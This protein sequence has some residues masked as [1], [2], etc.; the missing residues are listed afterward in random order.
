MTAPA[1]QLLALSGPAAVFDLEWTAWEG[2]QAR[3][4]SGPGELQEIVEIGAVLLDAGDGLRETGAFSMLV[5][6]GRNPRLS[7]YFIRLT[8]ITQEMVEREGRSFPSALAAFCRFVGGEGHGGPAAPLLSFGRDPGVLRAN[9]ALAGIACP[10][11][12]E[13]FRNVRALLSG[14]VGRAEGSFSSCDLPRLLGFAP[15]T[16]A[17]RALGDARCIAEA[18]RRWRAAAS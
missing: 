8:G 16:G 10:L 4:W 12:P 11:A 7:D 2:S 15:P 14:F 3:D 6:P 9:C 13:R 17:H 18:L 5:R 1:P